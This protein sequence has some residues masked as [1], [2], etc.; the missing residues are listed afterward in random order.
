MVK[1][2]FLIT[3][4]FIISFHIKA[5][6]LDSLD[7]NLP[8]KRIEQKNTSISFIPPE[9]FVQKK[10]SRAFIHKA[11]ASSLLVFEIPGISYKLYKDT[12]NTNY[13]RSQNLTLINRE[14]KRF[15][16]GE[17]GYLIEC[18]FT[19]KSHT[20][21]RLMYVTGS[22]HKTILFLANYPEEIKSDIKKPI[23]KSIRS[24]HYDPKP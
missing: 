24:L 1:K 14:K 16:E 4:L 3:I 2:I 18:K 5:Q 12:L 22:M 15:S 11:T 17:E 19:V 23:Y 8:P 10:G 20:F 21:H 13:F 6:N 9:G 7:N